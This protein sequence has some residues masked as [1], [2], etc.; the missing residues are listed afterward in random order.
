MGKVIT[1]PPGLEIAE[2]SLRVSL[3]TAVALRDWP[4]AEVALLRY[5]HYLE[6]IDPLGTIPHGSP[7][8]FDSAHRLVR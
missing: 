4:L 2:V 8:T 6:L 3:A 7:R 1:N 5:G